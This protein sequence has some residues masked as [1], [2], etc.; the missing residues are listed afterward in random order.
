MGREAGR[1]AKGRSPRE[2]RN[3]ADRPENPVPEGL[4]EKGPS[5]VLRASAS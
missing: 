1:E 2:R 4:P 5:A 3:E